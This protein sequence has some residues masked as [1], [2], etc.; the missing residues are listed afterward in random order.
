MYTGNPSTDTFANSED[1][2]EMPH[3]MAFHR[4]PPF[5]KVKKIL[6]KKYILFFENYNTT[7]QD[8]YNGL[9]QAHCI[10]SEG[11]IH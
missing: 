8:M 6:D 4:S 3:N 7:P 1:P 9:S 2:D 10:N 5:V 11:K